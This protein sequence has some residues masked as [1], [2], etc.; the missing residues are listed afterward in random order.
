MQAI[1]IV[2]LAAGKGKRMGDSDRPKVLH[3]L[4]GRPMLTY[5]LDAVVES[6][7]DAKPVLVIGHM[8]EHVKQVCGDACEYALQPEALGTG[9]AVRRAR[10]L[11]EG[12][13]EHV[14]VMV[15]DQPFVT[16]RSIRKIADMHLA[17]GATLT[18]GTVTIEDF[19]GW[20]KPFADFGRI[21]RDATG[22]LSAIIEARDASAEQLAVK[23]VNPAIYCFKA[24]WLWKGLETLTADNAQGELY[25]TDLLAKAIAAGEKVTTVPVPAKEAVGV[26]TIEQ[27][28]A[29]EKLMRTRGGAGEA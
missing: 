23:E 22:A 26:N 7:V 12:R 2:I 16:A 27:L 11:L 1:R 3:T 15:G 24:G 13:T 14:L 19:E 21:I 20:R 29:A 5:V 9:D 10:A 17:T 28:V 8:A 18:I 4:L 25:L 6:G